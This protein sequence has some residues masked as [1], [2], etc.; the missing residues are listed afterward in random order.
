[1]IPL[2]QIEVA[3]DDGGSGLVA[4]GDQLVQILVGRWA[5]RFEAEVIDDQQR[6]AGEVGEVM[7]GDAIEDVEF[8]VGQDDAVRPTVAAVFA[9]LI[10]IR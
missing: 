5:Q 6:N 10:R 8:V 9:S 3:G 4:F 7:P 1:M 2:R